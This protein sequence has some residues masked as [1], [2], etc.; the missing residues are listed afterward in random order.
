MNRRRIYLI[1]LEENLT[2]IFCR[3]RYRKYD[4]TEM[5]FSA[6]FLLFTIGTIRGLL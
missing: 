6:E 4:N 2:E 3:P 1:I 5:V